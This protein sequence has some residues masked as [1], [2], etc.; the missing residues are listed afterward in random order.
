MPEIAACIVASAPTVDSP[1]TLAILAHFNVLNKCQLGECIWRENVWR[2]WQNIGF[3]NLPRW[4]E[5][6]AVWVNMTTLS[7]V[8]RHTNFLQMPV[9]HEAHVLLRK[10]EFC[11]SSCL[12]YKARSLFRSVSLVMSAITFRVHKNCGDMRHLRGEVRTTVVKYWE[13]ANAVLK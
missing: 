13:T 3:W 10:C 5:G 7:P 2:D 6:V 8:D 12:L 9:F 1:L 4:W 11:A